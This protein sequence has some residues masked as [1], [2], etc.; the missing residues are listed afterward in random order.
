MDI[1]QLIHSLKNPFFD[2]LM[3]SRQRL[4]VKIEA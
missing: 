4:S 3:C 1:R 2:L